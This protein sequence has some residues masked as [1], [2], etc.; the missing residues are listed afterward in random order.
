VIDA[1]SDPDMLARRV[2]A[3]E[4][5]I[6]AIHEAGNDHRRRERELESERDRYR[7]DAIAAREAALRLNAAAAEARAAA[8]S[9]LNALDAQADALTQLLTPGSPADLHSG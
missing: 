2:V 7:S 1:A 5:Q 8:G 3:L 4:R 9:L 6:A